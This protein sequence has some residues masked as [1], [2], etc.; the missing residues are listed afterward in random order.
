MRR[1]KKKGWIFIEEGEP[2]MVLF[3]RWVTQKD[4]IKIY[5]KENT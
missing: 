1:E 4:A 2:V 3:R 5:N